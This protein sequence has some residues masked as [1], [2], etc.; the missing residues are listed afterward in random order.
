MIAAGFG[1][2]VLVGLVFLLI[3]IW[4][5]VLGGKRATERLTQAAELE[6]KRQYADRLRQAKIAIDLA[7]KS[8]GAVTPVQLA[9]AQSIVAEDKAQRR[10]RQFRILII[11]VVA[12]AIIA[13]G[14]RKPVKTLSESNASGMRLRHLLPHLLSLFRLVWESL[15]RR[16]RRCQFRRC[17]HRQISL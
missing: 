10:A 3:S 9:D 4:T 8:P 15:L 6:Q 7:A 14:E 12:A 16:V 5:A 2:L 1:L 11:V 17:R 13:F